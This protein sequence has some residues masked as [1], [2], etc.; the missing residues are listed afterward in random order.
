MGNM[1]Y[2]AMRDLGYKEAIGGDDL[3][4]YEDLDV[5]CVII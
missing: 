5:A 4:S 2:R 3:K 1:R